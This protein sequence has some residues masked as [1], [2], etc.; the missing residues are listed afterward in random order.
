MAVYQVQAN[1]DPDAKVWVAE[2]DDVPGLVTEADTFEHL[3]EKLRRMIPELLRLNGIEPDTID[4][5][6]PF[7]VMAQRLEHVRVA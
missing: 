5:D 1:W 2:S 3:I 4:H 7:N 6:V